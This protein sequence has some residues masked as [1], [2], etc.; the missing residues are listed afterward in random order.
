MF[1]RLRKPDR[2]Q[3][4][5]TEVKSRLSTIVDLPDDLIDGVFD[6]FKSAVKETESF[7]HFISEE[8]L[9]E[10][11]RLL[12]VG[13]ASYSKDV[14]LGERLYVATAKDYEF[15]HKTFFQT[16]SGFLSKQSEKYTQESIE[17]K[18]PGAINWY[19]THLS[20]TLADAL[21]YLR[22][23]YAESIGD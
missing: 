11:F 22:A 15:I 12:L 8:D 16:F 17:N 9:I 1:E 5:L 3:R 2:F 20:L 10:E 18:T 7:E 14:S 19:I 4:I 21:R 23:R 6:V 13:I